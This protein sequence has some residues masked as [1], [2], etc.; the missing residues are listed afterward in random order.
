MVFNLFDDMVK[1][2]SRVIE[3]ALDI[4][5]AVVTMG[6]YGEFSKKNVSRL[7]ASGVS[8]YALAEAANVSV[9]VIQELID[10]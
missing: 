4:G 2:T 9:E 10:E 1:S 3:D 8:I 6:E 5:T 7:I